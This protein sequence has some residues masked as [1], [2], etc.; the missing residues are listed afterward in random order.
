V[1][2]DLRRPV[3]H[4]VFDPTGTGTLGV[5]DVLA[6]GATVEQALIK[7]E[8]NGLKILQAGKP[9]EDPSSL[10]RGKNVNHLRERLA[11]LADIVVYDSPPVLVVAD[12]L[13]LARGA[14]LTILVNEAS[15][16]RRGAA[17]RAVEALKRS[18]DGVITTVLTKQKTGVSGYGYEYG[19]SSYY[20]V[21]EEAGFR[22]V[23]LNRVHRLASKS[24]FWK[25]PHNS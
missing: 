19:Y 6:G 7:T 14:D 5:A 3:Q 15:G 16:T 13:L 9:P 1:D 12:P 24:M 10:L 22:A 21:Q 8:I 18:S 2:T 23:T 25:R 17:S 20:G 4:L 11:E